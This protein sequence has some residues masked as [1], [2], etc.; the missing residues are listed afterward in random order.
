MPNTYRKGLHLLPLA[1]RIE[2]DAQNNLVAW[3]VLGQMDKYIDAMRQVRILRHAET[4]RTIGERREYL[5]ANGV[6]L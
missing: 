4:L 3:C 1:D 5:N 2:A 6:Y